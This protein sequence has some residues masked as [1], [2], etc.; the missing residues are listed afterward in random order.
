METRITTKK[1]FKQFI[2]SLSEEQV[3]G[4][5]LNELAIVLFSQMKP[6]FSFWELSQVYN[7]K[8][9]IQLLILKR[10]QEENLNH[11]GL[12]NKKVTDFYAYKSGYENCVGLSSW[13]K[14]R[15]KNENI[16]RSFYKKQLLKEFIKT[17]GFDP[18][19]ILFN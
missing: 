15:F 11:A 2:E 12:I 14:V 17:Q 7:I 10:I 6:D 16:T 8:P 3:G 19:N 5:T 9:I 1:A 4:L 18:T 13:N